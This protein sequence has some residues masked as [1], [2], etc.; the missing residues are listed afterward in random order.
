M[1]FKLEYLLKFAFIV[2][3]LLL[4][5]NYIKKCKNLNNVDK[6]TKE[7]FNDLK[8]CNWKWYLDNHSDLKRAYGSDINKARRHY[9]NYGI[10]EERVCNK[11]GLN[12][13]KDCNWKWYLD[14]HP[15]VERKY[16]KD[17]NRIDRARNH[18]IKDGIKEGKACN[19]ETLKCDW[20]W[21][22]DNYPYLRRA[23]GSN[24]DRARKHYIN[25]GIREGKACNKETLKCDWNW[26]LNNYPDL[27]K[28]FRG[29]IKRARAHFFRSGN[30]EGKA[31][32]AKDKDAKDKIIN[33]KIIEDKMRK[34]DCS[35]ASVVAGF[36]ANVGKNSCDA[37]RFHPNSGSKISKTY[38]EATASNIKN[39]DAGL[40]FKKCCD[41]KR[42]SGSDRSKDKCVMKVSEVDKIIK[43]KMKKI[44]CYDSK[45]VDGWNSN[46]DKEKCD[47]ARNGGDI[48]SEY[49]KGSASKFGGIENQAAYFRKCCDYN[50]PLN[51]CVLKT[52]AK[53]EISKEF[54]DRKRD[55]ENAIAETT[56]K[57]NQIKTI[58]DGFKNY[59]K[60]SYVL[61][62]IDRIKK[63]ISNITP[64]PLTTP[65]FVESEPIKENDELIAKNE[66]N[67]YQLEK[68]LKNVLKDRYIE[69]LNDSNVIKSMENGMRLSI[70]KDKKNS[71]TEDKYRVYVNNKCL[72]IDCSG[73][74]NLENC[75]DNKKE[76]LFSIHQIQDNT[77]YDAQLEKMNDYDVGI[78]SQKYPFTILKSDKTGNC[79]QN[80]SNN[81]SIQPCQVRH[82]QQWKLLNTDNI[83]GNLYENKC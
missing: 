74:Y 75:N 12:D 28:A 55:I 18:Y 19:K 7:G 54:S 56:K 68:K 63:N 64:K 39:T 31:C 81:I 71:D 36:N 8:D 46:Q 3:I 27:K 52:S 22:L 59:K 5:I 29:D 62:Y 14:N 67:I 35:N 4:I 45:Y 53:E 1:I 33:D 34:I 72:N 50:E 49:C 47:A 24:I 32:S 70:V 77:E 25:Y 76:Q 38:C 48:Y 10:R 60:K 66:K 41:F 44:K 58:V 2:I 61:N 42:D 13:L 26:Y 21:Y 37:A 40:Y 57:K 69:S 16:R 82:S 15:D 9:I 80:N 23:Y 6:N 17:I 73:D 51:K 11:E 79:L 83:C 65:E 30:K 43:D 20:N 78:D